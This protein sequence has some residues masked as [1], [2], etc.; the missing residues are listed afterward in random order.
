MTQ[1][2]LK[3]AINDWQLNYSTSDWVDYYQ[4][5]W[6]Y[7]INKKDRQ[8]DYKRNG[9]INRNPDSVYF[10]DTKITIKYNNVLFSSSGG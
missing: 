4:N 1:Q 6:Q 7:G 10:G 5:I 2:E 8:R 3:R 9:T